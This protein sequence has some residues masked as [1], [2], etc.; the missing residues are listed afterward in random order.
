MA[1]RG[2]EGWRE[3]VMWGALK[4]LALVIGLAVILAAGRAEAG[5]VTFKATAADFRNPERGFWRQANDD[6]LAATA[7][8]LDYA[9]QAGTLVYAPVRLDSYRAKDLPQA[10]LDK[11]TAQ[12]AKVRAKG[13]KVILRFAYNDGFTNGVGLDAKL[14]QVLRHIAQVKP[15]VRANADVVFVWEMGFIGAWGEGHSS[16]S[17][18]TSDASRKA[19]GNALLNAIP[20]DRMV[21]WRTPRDLKLWYPAV[22]ASSTRPRIGMFNDCFLSDTTDVG[23]FSDN[24]TTRANEKA[25]VASMTERAPF[26]GETCYFDKTTVGARTTCAAVAAEGQRFH[27]TFLGR[28]YY[29]AF[30]KAW[31]A[32]GC[33]DAVSRTMGYRL[34]LTSATAPATVRR[35]AKATISVSLRNV[36]WAAPVNPRRLVLRVRDGRGNLVKTLYGA[37]LSTLAA[38][39]ARTQAYGWAVPSTLAAGTYTLSVA[40]PDSASAIAGQAAYAVRFANASQTSSAG[41]TQGWSASRGEFLLGLPLIVK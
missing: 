11:L 27:L 36:G 18:L 23:T 28:D 8:D 35:G 33:F 29:T 39:T 37:D 17:G 38:R 20:A 24:A 6:F 22:P 30:H 25:Y 26:G 12:F 13:L 5:T 4:G 19:I 10:V 7:D 41:A 9:A 34:E 2:G 1:H 40:A 14:A 15:V 16:S 21:M 32:G 31:I 3:G